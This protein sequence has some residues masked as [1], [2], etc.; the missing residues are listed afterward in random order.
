ML[1][2]LWHPNV[3]VLLCLL[4]P[5]RDYAARM[6]HW[7]H[8]AFSSFDLQSNIC[9][10]SPR[11][12]IV[13]IMAQFTLAPVCSLCLASVYSDF[14]PDCQH[15]HFNGWLSKVRIVINKDD[16]D[17]QDIQIK[18]VN[19]HLPNDEETFKWSHE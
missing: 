8:K 9:K 7:R 1:F 14:G 4:T 2:Q 12:E 16:P 10:L 3:G 13:H 15:Q 17:L 19:N 5:R 11:F 6:S 18:N